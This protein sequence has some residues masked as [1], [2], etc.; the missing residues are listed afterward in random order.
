MAALTS[1]PSAVAHFVESMQ[2]VASP[3]YGE[4]NVTLGIPPEVNGKC[5]TVRIRT[6][7]RR[8]AV[9]IRADRQRFAA[10]RVASSSF[11]R[12]PRSAT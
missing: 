11:E 7:G 6:D 2:Q 5:V 10:H 4:H 9:S 12:N 8:H 3:V 1:P